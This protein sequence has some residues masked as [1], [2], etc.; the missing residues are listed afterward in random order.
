MLIVPRIY[1]TISTHTQANARWSYTNPPLAQT[2]R[3]LRFIYR[4]DPGW[5]W[6]IFDHDQIEL[7]LVA[8]ECK[9]PTMLEGLA[10]R[11]DLHL[12]ACIGMFKL[13]TPPTLVDPIH[14]EANAD[15]RL[16]H[17]WQPCQHEDDLCG[18]DDIRRVFSKQFGH[19][20]DYGGTSKRAG[21][22]PGAKKLGLTQKDLMQM[23]TARAVM[24]P[25]LVQWQNEVVANG[26]KTGETRTWNGR[27][28]RY[29]SRGATY[30][31]GEMLDHPMQ[32]GVQD[33]ETMIFLAIA[34][35]F[36]SDALFKFGMH[37]SQ[38][39]AFRDVRYDEARV[40]VREIA[41]PTLVIAGTTMDF[42]A[43]FK[44]RMV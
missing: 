26:S 41:Q 13:E 31:K 37:D 43:S 10:K 12:M 20:A 9:D 16:L 38:T 36:G 7:R 35:Y 6:I 34:D 44:E 32:A 4:P 40:K 17:H 24:F 25:G 22:I 18:K 8:A 3:D 27:R 42:P 21:N 28:R 14:A 39:W 15:W 29:L 33:I 19:R 1:H 23:S 11:W 2:P 30:T 5:P